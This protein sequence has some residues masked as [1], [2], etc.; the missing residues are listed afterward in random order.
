MEIKPQKKIISI[1]PY[2][3]IAKV[4]NPLTK[5]ARK[6]FDYNWENYYTV[7]F[8]WLKWHYEI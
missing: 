5:E 6:A 2:I 1:I 8:G 7:Q 3:N 4:T